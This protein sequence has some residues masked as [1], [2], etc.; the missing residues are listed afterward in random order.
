[1]IASHG[2]WRKALISIFAFEKGLCHFQKA[3][4]AFPIG[5]TTCANL[6]IR[7]KPP[8]PKIWTTFRFY[9]NIDLEGNTN[10]PAPAGSQQG[11]VSSSPFA[12]L[13]S[14]LAVCP[15][16]DQKYSSQL[17]AKPGFPTVFR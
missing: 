12:S 15:A 3:R 2:T 10:R 16:A 14:Y 6:P 5:V 13:D 17:L 1:M 11:F 4:F 7:V 8:F 9:S